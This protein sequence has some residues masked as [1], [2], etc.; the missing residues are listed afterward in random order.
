[1]GAV[2]YGTRWFFG[3]KTVFRKMDQVFEFKIRNNEI[4]GYR[5][6]LYLQPTG[7]ASARVCSP[8]IPSKGFVS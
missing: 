7:P 4:S 8:Q 3:P 2:W 5:L 1:V 6:D